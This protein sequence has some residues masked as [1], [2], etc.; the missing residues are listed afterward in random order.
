MLSSRACRHGRRPLSSRDKRTRARERAASGNVFHKA[1]AQSVLLHVHRQPV[2]IRG[3][4]FRIFENQ[5]A[6]DV[7]GV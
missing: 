6:A 3:I 1:G 7:A 4:R 2:A 5:N